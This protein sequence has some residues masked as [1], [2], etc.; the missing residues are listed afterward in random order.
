MTSPQRR[1]TRSELGRPIGNSRC[2][3]SCACYVPV[4]QDLAQVWHRWEAPRACVASTYRSTCRFPSPRVFSVRGRN[5]GRDLGRRVPTGQFIRSLSCACHESCSGGR[6]GRETRNHEVCVPF[7]L[8]ENVVNNGHKQTISSIT[9]RYYSMVLVP[10][11][12]PSPPL[13]A[14]SQFSFS[15]PFS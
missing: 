15:F 6:E 8:A 13:P 1:A 4:G 7:F 5:T 14:P 9:C 12:F 10:W 2:G 11:L 3:T